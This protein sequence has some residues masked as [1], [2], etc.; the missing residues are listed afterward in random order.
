MEK[1]QAATKLEALSLLDSCHSTKGV[2]HT[3]RG[4][5]SKIVFLAMNA[6]NYS[7]DQPIK[8]CQMIH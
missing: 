6:A 7:N 4:K 3:T 5:K 2:I 1:N 8:T